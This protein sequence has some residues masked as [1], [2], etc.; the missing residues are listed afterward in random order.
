M[1]YLRE[2]CRQDI[3]EINEWRNSRELFNSLGNVFRHINIETDESWYSSYLQNRGNNVRCAICLSSTNEIIGVVYLLHIDYVSGSAEFAIMIGKMENQ[4]KG[5]GHLAT[6]QMLKHAFQ[7]LNLHRV[8]LSVLAGNQRAINMYRK[9]GFKEEG[10][11]RK[12]VYKN[13]EYH[14]VIVMGLLREEFEE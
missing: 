6:V 2:I 1:I 8:Y 4:G 7:D 10:T 14:D 3:P 13:G 12:A 9:N 5:I 11:L